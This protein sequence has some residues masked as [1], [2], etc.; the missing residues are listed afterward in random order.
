VLHRGDAE[1]PLIDVGFRACGITALTNALLSCER[2]TQ[3]WTQGW[4]LETFPNLVRP[5]EGRD[6]GSLAKYCT[7][8]SSK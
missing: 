1:R 4:R 7:L 5:L 6:H 3:R 2:P 8:H